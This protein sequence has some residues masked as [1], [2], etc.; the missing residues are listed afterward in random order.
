[1]KFMLRPQFIAENIFFQNQ[2]RSFQIKN[3]L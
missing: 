3:E 1:M 2:Y